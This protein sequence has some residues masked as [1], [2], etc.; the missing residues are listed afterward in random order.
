MR[1]FKNAISQSLSVDKKMRVLGFVKKE[2]SNVVVVYSKKN[3]CAQYN[4]IIMIS[5]RMGGV[6][7]YSF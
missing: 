1:L 6:S 5:R 4:H 7:A 3:E 2:E